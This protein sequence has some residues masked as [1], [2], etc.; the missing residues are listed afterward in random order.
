M[1]RLVYHIVL[2]LSFGFSTLQAHIK[3]DT[4]MLNGA[5]AKQLNNY[6]WYIEDS[7]HTVHQGNVVNHLNQDFLVKT[8]PENSGRFNPGY[9]KSHFW[10]VLK[11]K[12]NSENAEDYVW[13]FYQDGIMLHFYEAGPDQLT[14]LDVVSQHHRPTDK[15]FQTR[16]PAVKIRFQPAE[17]KTLLVHIVPT[18]KNNIYT[19][20]AMTSVEDY[21][22]DEQSNGLHMGVFYG[23]VVFA[24]IANIFLFFVVKEPIYL[25]MLG[26]LFFLLAFFMAEYSFDVFL[27]P[28]A[29]FPVWTQIPKI[30]FS[31]MIMFFGIRMFLLFTNFKT[32]FP[33]VYE[34]IPWFLSILLLLSFA[35]LAGSFAM[36]YQHPI[37]RT[38]RTASGH[39]TN[40]AMLVYVALIAYALL[41]GNRSAVWFFVSNTLLFLN[42]FAIVLNSHGI[43]FMSDGLH[44]GNI[45][46]G[47]L[48]EVFLLSFFFTVK[49]GRE[50]NNMF[51]LKL[52]NAQIR[53]SIAQQM[54]QIQ[55][56]ERKSMARELHDVIGNGLSGIRIVL[57][58]YFFDSGRDKRKE[59]V[60]ITELENIY[61]EVRALS[62][63]LMPDYIQERKLVELLEMKLDYYRKN[64][65]DIIFNF[66][67]DLSR[68]PIKNETKLHLYR[69]IIELINNSIKHAKCSEISLQLYQSDEKLE[70]AIE[71]NGVGFGAKP[72]DKGGIGLMNVK[73]RIQYLNGKWVTESDE[74]G[75]SHMTEIPINYG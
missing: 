32:Y 14:L 12:N 47:L 53:E 69:I 28:T 42:A 16:Y 15:K 40:I 11:A 63:E 55:E 67:H 21:L 13:S 8:K 22:M 43:S 9:T 45:R 51:S 52:E 6:Y 1:P 54:I 23:F 38:L 72:N 5:N 36:T 2:L 58:N 35:L 65:P 49:Y 57:Q 70:I 50:R 61:K 48:T 44:L 7:L 27:V 39:A 68:S 66:N 75:T 33:K 74:K 41:K 17:T 4:L 19:T 62:H 71:D 25:N 3:W 60:I 56:N 31:S 34:A 18:T 26:Y 24:L 59:N 20:S 46:I 30:F 64:F 29:I 37:L 10:L 73:S